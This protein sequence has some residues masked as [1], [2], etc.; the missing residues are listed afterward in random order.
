LEQLKNSNQPI[1]Q[2]LK[3]VV[4][5]VRVASKSQQEPWMEGSI[6][7]D[8]C[9]SK[10][11][12]LPENS[13]QISSIDQDEKF[14]E[15]SKSIGTKEGYEAY[16]FQFPNGRFA[17][18]AKA[19]IS[20]LMNTSPPATAL[21]SVG[22]N[23][24]SVPQVQASPNPALKPNN[25]NNIGIPLTNQPNQ[26]PSTKVTVLITGA[27]ATY[28]FP[29][30]AKWAEGY[31][32]TSGNILNYQSIGSSGGIRQIKAK[33]VTF[34]ATDAPLPAGDLDNAGLIQ[35]PTILGGTV[36]VINLDG[37]K[38]G[39]LKLTGNVLSEIFMGKIIKWND[40]RIAVLN[41]SKKLPDQ[42]ITIVHRADGSGTTF[43]FTDY[44]TKASKDWA[45]SV[46][47]G[48]AVKWPAATSVGG[49][50]NAGVASLL[51]SIK[52]SIGYLEYAYFKN[53]NMNC[54]QLLNYDG[55][56]VVPN[57][58]TIAAAA[59][60]TDWF[61]V[62]GM[63]VSMV[64]AK[65]AASW[66]ISYA[67]FI[68]MPTQPTDKSASLEAI[69]FF[70]WSFINGKKMASDLSYIPLPDTLTSAIRAKVWTQIQH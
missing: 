20:K 60:G 42:A 68:L 55:Q 37:F 65:G 7:G 69:K 63:G 66:P 14:W 15:D 13:S 46:G 48:A 36:P 57:D 56:Y 5:G 70:D 30:Y 40:T 49:K 38:S 11:S 43:N 53:N 8:F 31:K 21:S 34:G 9:F 4:S 27:G 16:L 10:C 22:M 52:G 45:S 62:P 44:L 47:S 12:N 51:N 19:Q 3:K 6:E 2:V 67:S 58:S 29:A 1:E 23:Q 41:P 64:D 18:L 26:L 32:A 39:E 50:G 33:T 24:N 28:P 35:F 59:S 61:S 54:V 25:P 17:G